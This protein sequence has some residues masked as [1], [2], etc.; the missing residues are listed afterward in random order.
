MHRA[1]G[2]NTNALFPCLGID[3]KFY[4]CIWLYP[5]GRGRIWYIRA[6]KSIYMYI[7][8]SLAIGKI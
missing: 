7:Y 1:I 5:E 3:H 4:K 8:A 2:F 6:A